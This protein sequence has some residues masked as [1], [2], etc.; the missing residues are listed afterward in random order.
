MAKKPGNKEFEIYALKIMNKYTPI[1]MLNNFTFKIKYG[2]ENE[3]S[4]ME[5]VTNYPYLDAKFN[6]GGAIIKMWKD[7]ED[8]EPVIIHEMCHL[9]TDPLFCKAI[10]RYATEPE[11][12]HEREK[13]TDYISNIITKNKL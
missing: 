5:S 3:Y 6:Y 7:G 12:R 1:L 4:L 8:I 2:L 11:I 10:Q 9:I 13:L